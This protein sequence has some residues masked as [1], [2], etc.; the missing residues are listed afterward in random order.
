MSA[1]L[2]GYNMK[3][4]WIAVLACLP[5]VA[6]AGEGSIS[7][8]N[9]SVHVS[10]GESAGN[11]ST[12]NGGVTIEEGA[13]A[14]DVETVNGSINI[15]RNVTVQDVETVNGGITLGSGAKAA[16]IETVNGTL[17]LGE[18]VQVGGDVSAVNGS[19]QL[20]KGADI[21]GE[22]SNV[23]GKMTL[24]AAHV[25]GGLH[26][27]N[28]DIT[29][30]ADSRVEG[31]ILVEKPNMSWFSRSRRDPRIVIG[32]RAV[33]A[34]TLKFEHDVELLVSDR[35]KI[36]PVEGAKPTTF[37]GDEPGKSED[38]ERK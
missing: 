38:V 37:S 29:V 13:T 5:L 8:V 6:L 33:V 27:V 30:G 11:V 16:R 32:P 18:G 35:A 36:G 21:R 17:R 19:A 26:T 25:G 28:G 9:G 3:N 14:G 23:N 20:E 34:G 22:L 2:K 24:T 12:V 10:A 15:A 31:G 1:D 4:V 7:K